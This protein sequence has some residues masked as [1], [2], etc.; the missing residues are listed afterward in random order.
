MD[1]DKAVQI[2]D[3][4]II[5]NPKVMTVGEEYAIKRKR[6]T[7]RYRLLNDG[8]S[9]ILEITIGRK[10]SAMLNLK[11][12]PFKAFLKSKN[13]NSWIRFEDGDVYVRK[14]QRY[15]HGLDSPVECLDIANVS[16]D[17][18]APSGFMERMMSEAEKVAFESG[19]VVY[20]ENVI[21]EFLPQWFEKRG[22][23]QCGNDSGIPSYYKEG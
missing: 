5:I 22:Y 1:K 7:Y 15:L 4:K 2:V 21:N 14:A 10:R 12:N 13:R 8:D 23:I 6:K 3:G 11:S 19:R 20:V 17:N 16:R 18:E 9:N